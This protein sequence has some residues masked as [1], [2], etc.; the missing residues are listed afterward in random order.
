MLRADGS[1]FRLWPVAIGGDAHEM[2]VEQR[3]DGSLRDDTLD[4]GAAVASS[5]SPVF[6]ED[7]F[8]FALRLCERVGQTRM[9]AHRAAIIKM[10]MR[11]FARLR[12]LCV[13]P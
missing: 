11:T 7:E 5:V 3:G 10:R 1:D 12:H 2:F 9:P 6:D 4:E 13:L 8:P